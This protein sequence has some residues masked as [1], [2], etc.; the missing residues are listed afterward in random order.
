M[1]SRPAF[2]V[3]RPAGS[4]RYASAL[5]VL[6]LH[7]ALI[8]GLMSHRLIPVP[9]EAATLFVNF[10]APPAPQ[11]A[12]APRQPVPPKPRAIEKPQPRQLVAEAP[13]TAPAEFVAPPPPKA[14]PV[15]EAPAMPL[16]VAPVALS[17]ELSLVCP[18]RTPPTYPALSLR[19][20]E[21]GTTILHV[22]L[23]A[24]GRVTTATVETG[25]GYP[26]LDEAALATVKTW[27]CQPPRRNGQPTAAIAR[28]PFKFVLQEN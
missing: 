15:I 5:V 28:Q 10:I 19:R 18:E 24:D 7:A 22:E 26:R 2:A 17:G 20:G 14:T 8:G 16:P 23:G 25:S 1:L 9:M 21:S 4:G 13:V 27:R 11:Q 12:E 6:G 3:D